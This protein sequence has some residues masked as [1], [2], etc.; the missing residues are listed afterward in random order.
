MPGAIEVTPVGG[1]RELTEFIKV[2][3]GLHRGTPWVP[4]LVSERRRFLDRS[5]NPYFDHAEAEYFLARRD[6]RP[7]GRISAQVDRRWDEFQGGS[8]AQF[9]FIDA[10]DDPQVFAALLGAAEE[11]ARE[12]GRERLIGPM[13]FTTN[14]ECGLLIEGYD[15]RPMILEPWHPQYYRERIEARGYGK[16]IDLLMWYLRMG[17]LKEG[18]RFHPAIHEMA[19]KVES[20]HGVTIRNMRRRD[21]TS[22]IAGF[23]EVYNA[24]WERN[25][26]FVPIT[27]AEVEFQAKNLKPILDER[28]TFV[29]ERDGEVLG[30]AL[31]LPDINQVLAKMNGRLLPAG[32]L[33]FLLGKRKIDEVRVFALGVKPE[34]QHLGIAANFYIK[35]L[36]AT[37]PDGVMA[38][39]QGWILET[40][41]PMNRAM[42][43]MGGE[44]VKKYRLFEKA[45]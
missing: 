18:L 30:A 3:F 41:E 34:Y 44:V 35:H 29:A 45:L 1:R 42:E 24:A 40:N 7:V 21:L 2:P 39:E 20:E 22:E 9:G 12:R 17:D 11:W 26:G 37:D 5:A 43:G 31:T 36:E 8:D 6:G 23:M 38:G 33:R 13:D 14:D 19:E 4:P 10:E 27:E 16:K 25:W 32:W 15:R 28:W